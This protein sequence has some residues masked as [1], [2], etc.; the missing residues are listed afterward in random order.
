MYWPVEDIERLYI[1]FAPSIQTRTELRMQEC[2]DALQLFA[3]ANGN[4]K[5]LKDRMHSRLKDFHC[6]HISYITYNESGGGGQSGLNEADL[7]E[8]Q[9]FTTFTQRT[10]YLHVRCAARVLTV[11]EFEDPHANPQ[12]R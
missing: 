7:N 8:P 5:T 11:W 3:L 2:E 9:V 6:S 12:W 1:H 4:W 10:R